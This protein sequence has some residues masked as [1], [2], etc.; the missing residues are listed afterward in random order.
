MPRRQGPR[1]AQLVLVAV[2]L[3]VRQPHQQSV[4]AGVGD[5]TAD[6]LAGAF[7]R[8]AA[9]GEVGPVALHVGG[10]VG[11]H[12]GV[13]VARRDAQEQSV[14]LADAPAAELR[15]LL[16][17]VPED[18]AERRF[19]PQGLLD[20]LGHRHLAAVELGPEAR[21]GE[22]HAQHVGEEVGGG[23]VGGD[24]DQPQVLPDLVVG[25]PGRVVDE[26][27]GE[28]LLGLGPAACGEPGQGVHDV[29]VA[30]DRG[31]GALEHVAGGVHDPV[32][33]LVGHAEDLAH[34]RHREMVGEL[35][36]QVGPALLAEAVDEGLRGAVDEP[37]QAPVVDGRHGAGDRAAQPQMLVALGVG[38]DG[39]P[40]E[41][42][43][44]RVV[45][46]DLTGPQRGPD[47]AVAGEVRGTAHHVQVLAVAE[48][49]PDGNVVVEQR[50]GHGTVFR[51]EFLVQGPQVPCLGAVQP[52]HSAGSAAVGRAAGRRR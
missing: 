18:G 10:E 29:L 28:V 8:A 34:H 49:H 15:V 1:P 38:A 3:D 39:L 31:L 40:G 23:L 4:D 12:P 16:G 2:E 47:A 7:V 14:A 32:V 27:G 24:Q 22:H 11:P 21:V 6:V 33:V 19:V 25:E 50:G 36:D 5:G 42:R 20:R 51:T 48:H 26:V 52:V 13:D 44:Q 37:A 9:E 43:R 45:G 46:R 35:C 30:R 41:V 17:E